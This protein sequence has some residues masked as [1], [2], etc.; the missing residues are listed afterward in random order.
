MALF[1]V[2]A[3]ISTYADANEYETF[4]GH[5]Y[6]GKMYPRIDIIEWN[7]GNLPSHMEFQNYN[8]ADMPVDMAFQ[9]EEK[10]GRK[11]M[12]VKYTIHRKGGDEVLCR[13]V[14]APGHFKDGMYMVY[15]DNADTDR[16]ITMVSMFPLPEKKGRELISA[17]P[18]YASCEAPAPDRMPAGTSER[19]RDSVNDD[20]K[21]VPS[22]KGALKKDGDS[23]PFGDW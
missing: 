10:N 8:K 17:A 20:Q 22:N 14:I 18:R 23:V 11:V 7:E 9:L 16:E 2:G 15:K 1:G 12:L 21:R 6:N 3:F 19:G 4:D 5:V 13:R